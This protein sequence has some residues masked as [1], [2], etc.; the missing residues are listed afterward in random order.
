MKRRKKASVIGEIMS[1]HP[2]TTIV[3]VTD[4]LKLFIQENGKEVS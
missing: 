4:F 3:S 1:G 2:I